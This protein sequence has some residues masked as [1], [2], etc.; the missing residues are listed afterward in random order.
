M[1]SRSFVF[2]ALCMLFGASTMLKAGDLSP[3][4]VAVCGPGARGGQVFAAGESVSNPFG[5]TGELF[6]LKS[7]FRML[8]LIPGVTIGLPGKPPS[9]DSLFS[10]AVE[11]LSW[12]ERVGAA[13]DS[14]PEAK[15][16][17][18]TV[19][20]FLVYPLGAVLLD[21]P[22]AFKWQGDSLESEF[23]LYTYTDRNAVLKLNT[24]EGRV[25]RGQCENLIQPLVRYGWK[26]VSPAHRDSSWFEVL[27][28]SGLMELGALL[29]RMESLERR[30]TQDEDRPFGWT[31]L[32][33]ALL[34]RRGLFYEARALVRTQRELVPEQA[35]ACDILL[36]RLRLLQRLGG[37]Q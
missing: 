2:L 9:P 21:I 6:V 18:D 13:L 26:A 29:E 30:D 5:S 22:E 8:H 25:R 11:A 10:Q 36:R 37:S 28:D 24:R 34:A 31:W 32:K 12:F 35:A 7:D 27:D 16:A 14:L 19:E 17:P 1:K 20:G 4:A 33:A 23:I 15:A 3:A